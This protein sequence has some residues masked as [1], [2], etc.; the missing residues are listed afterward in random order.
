MDYNM[1]ECSFFID[2]PF[3]MCDILFLIIMLLSTKL[4]WLLLSSPANA[5]YFEN[6][7]N[8][9]KHVVLL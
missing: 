6:Y 1:F 7:A 5:R 9:I 2:S 3:K 8:D 4:R